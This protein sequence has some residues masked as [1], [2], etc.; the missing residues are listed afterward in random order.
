M[1]AIVRCQMKTV[2][3]L[4]YSESKTQASRNWSRSVDDLATE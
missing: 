3:E 4:K 1:G 2:V